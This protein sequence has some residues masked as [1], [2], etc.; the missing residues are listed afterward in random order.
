MDEIGRGVHAHQDEVVALREHVLVHL[1]RALRHDDQVEAELA[2]LAGDPDRVL[3]GERRERVAGLGRADVVRLVDH[4]RHRL[5]ARAPA[6]E[7]LEHR[8]RGERLLLARRRASRGRPPVQRAPAGS[9]EL[10]HQR[11]ALGARPHAPAVHAEVARPQLQRLGVRRARGPRGC[12]RSR[13]RSAS[14]SCA[15]S[16]R[17]DQ[18]V[19]PQRGRLV[20][21]A[22]LPEAHADARRGRSCRCAPRRRP[23]RRRS[24]RRGRPRR[25]RAARPG[26]RSRS[27]GRAPPPAGCVS[28]SRCSSSTPSE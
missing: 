25:A 10:L 17:S 16:S 3:G 6:P 15:Y 11:L 14:M 23:R 8:A 21:G 28:I 26:A 12:A 5:A 13:P 2:A 1:L 9:L 7:P 18:R 27:S 19:E 4:D 24:A 20:G 22:Q